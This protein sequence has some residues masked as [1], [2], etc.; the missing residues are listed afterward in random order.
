MT[1]A[2]ANAPANGEALYAS[3]FAGCHGAGV[4]GGIGP[5]ILGTAAWTPADFQQAVLHG[6]ASGAA[7]WPR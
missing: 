4:V 3:T 6:Q 1:A 5:S 2:V 7:P